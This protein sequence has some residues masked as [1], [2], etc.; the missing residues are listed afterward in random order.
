MFDVG[1]R[2]SF[3]S[4]PRWVNDIRERC[5]ENVAIGII[6]HKIDL[7]T[8]NVSK[9]EGESMASREQAFY[10]ETTIYDVQTIRNVFDRLAQGI[11]HS[12]NLE[13]FKSNKNKNLSFSRTNV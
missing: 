12:N 10:M 9:E 13:I 3:S 6:G 11:Y 2:T 8:R 1:S 4:I 7:Q 5:N